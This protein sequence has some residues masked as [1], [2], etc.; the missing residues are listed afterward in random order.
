MKKI[1]LASK[2]QHKYEEFQEILEPFGYEVISLASLNDNDEVEE[3]G[4]TFKD[5]A[6]IKARYYYDKY[7]LDTISDDS[8]I[9]LDYLGGFPGIYSARFLSQLDYPTKNQL[10]IDMYE[11]VK[12]RNAHY[13]CDIAL[14]I[15]GHEEVFEGL[16]F[17]KV[18]Y[19]QSGNN[20]FGYDPMFYLPSEGKTSADMSQEYKNTHS[21]RAIAL[22]KMVAYLEK[23]H[24]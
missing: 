9:S 5:N 11:G 2:N 4:K 18:A 13:T 14:I 16:W 8:G 23:K 15:D 21:H 17:G 20:G 3:T 1:L 24:R 12:N 22:E 19:K 10:I 6:L 7:H